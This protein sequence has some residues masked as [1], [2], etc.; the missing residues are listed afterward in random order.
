MYTEREPSFGLT[1]CI[2]TSDRKW[3]TDNKITLGVNKMSL[4]APVVLKVL[5]SI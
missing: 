1:F 4:E 5:Y 3:Y 2:K